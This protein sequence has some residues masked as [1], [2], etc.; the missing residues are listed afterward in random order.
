M[1]QHLKDSTVYV[2]ILK[3]LSI[4]SPVGLI[5]QPIEKRSEGRDE[6]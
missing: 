6:K 3:H 1:S 5:L 2:G 4:A